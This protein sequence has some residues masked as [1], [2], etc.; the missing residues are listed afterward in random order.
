MYKISNS[1]I[2]IISLALNK[3]RMITLL[4]LNLLKF[5]NLLIVLYVTGDDK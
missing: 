2:L 5:N 3:E 1:F 4:G